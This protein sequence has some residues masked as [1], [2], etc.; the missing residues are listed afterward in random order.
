MIYVRN[1]L[2]TT[3]P[4]S[5]NSGKRNAGKIKNKGKPGNGCKVLHNTPDKTDLIE[6]EHIVD[7]IKS[8][9]EKTI[10]GDD[11]IL[12]LACREIA[13]TYTRHEKN[14]K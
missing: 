9:F 8:R 3:P 6:L 7:D 1:G 4:I 13:N 2:Q 11:E 12:L 14:Y 5:G 10:L